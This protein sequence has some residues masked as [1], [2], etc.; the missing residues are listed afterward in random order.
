MPDT[1]DRPHYEE[2]DNGSR[3]TLAASAH[4]EIDV[5]L[6]PVA[7][8]DVPAPPEFRNAV[9]HIRIVEVLWEVE[10]HHLSETYRHI[11]VSAEIKVDL[12]RE[13]KDTEPR[14]HCGDLAVIHRLYLSPQQTYVVGYEHLLAKPDDES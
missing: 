3:Q 10:S 12:E 14:R 2:V 7:E 8:R 9:R 4:R 13:R 5:A 11:G 6:E 1:G